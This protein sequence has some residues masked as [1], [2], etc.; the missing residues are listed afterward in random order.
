MTCFEKN[1]IIIRQIC[2]K[3]EPG[4]KMLQKLMYL[5]SRKGVKLELNY[6]IHYFGPYSSKLDGTLHTLESFDKL[7]INTSG[8]THTIHLGDS[9]IEGTLNGKE[10]ESVDFV[11]KNFLRRSAHELEAITTIDYVATTILKNQA[12]DEEI[13]EKVQQ[14]KGTKFSKEY[15][16]DCLQTLKR[17][18]YIA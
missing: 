2:D 14:I 7:S 18:D 5:I 8:I 12:K 11:L 3:I 9:P 10:Q 1:S 16:Q 6:S 4:K 13:I 17:L 15:L